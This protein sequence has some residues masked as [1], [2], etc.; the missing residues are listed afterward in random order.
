[1]LHLSTII[2]TNNTIKTYITQITVS[3][4]TYIILVPRYRKYNSN[5]NL[6]PI[7]GIINHQM[8]TEIQP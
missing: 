7:R 5:R 3:G 4:A 8:V 2:R 6:S 1:M